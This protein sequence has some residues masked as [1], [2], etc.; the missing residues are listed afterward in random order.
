MLGDSS[1]A[2]FTEGSKR[3]TT[4]ANLW[5]DVRD[6]ILRH[7]PWNCAKKRVLL[8]P[9]VATPPFGFSFNFTKPGD[10]LRTLQVGEDY[11]DIP[12]ADES[13]R[14]LCDLNPLP[15]RYLWRNANPATY[16][17]ML[18]RVMTLAMAAQLAYPITSSAAV[19]QTRYQQLELALRR[20]ASV[21]GQ[22]DGPEDAG[23]FD[24]LTARFRSRYSV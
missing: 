13:G 24:L 8:A 20:A 6:D 17:S 7:K 1:I 4:A 18:V 12:F 19:E 3:A 10:W 22:D 9:E 11:C 5:P 21:D 23:H 2:S 16:D 14:I 15:L